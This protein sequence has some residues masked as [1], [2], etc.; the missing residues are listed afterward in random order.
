MSP[1]GRAL[2]ERFG[3]VCRAELRRLHKKT[4]SLAPEHRDEVHALTLEIAQRMAQR[5]DSAVHS[6]GGELA[7][8]VMRLFAVA[9]DERSESAVARE[10]AGRG[11]RG[12]HSSES[13]E[14]K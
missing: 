9:A 8:V 14:D 3:S 10:R 5:L 6:G 7:A 11:V 1:V 2:E 12:Q 13:V 4:A